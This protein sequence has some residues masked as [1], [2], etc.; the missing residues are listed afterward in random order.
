MN[1]W[2]IAS[3]FISERNKL[4]TD[5]TLHV[6]IRLTRQHRNRWYL[7]Y[8]RVHR[9]GANWAF[10][11]LMHTT[12]GRNACLS[13]RSSRRFVGR[14]TIRFHTH[15]GEFGL[16]RIGF[17]DIHGGILL[18]GVTETRFEIKSF[19]L[20]AVNCSE[21]QRAEFFTWTACNKSRRRP[22]YLEKD[23]ALS[24]SRRPIRPGKTRK[25]LKKIK[26][27]CLK[28]SKE[29]SEIVSIDQVILSTIGPLPPR[30]K[31]PSL[32]ITEDCSPMDPG[33]IYHHHHHQTQSNSRSTQAAVALGTK[34]AAG[35]WVGEQGLL[36]SSGTGRV[37]PEKK[38]IGAREG[39]RTNLGIGRG[40]R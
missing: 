28:S 15:G 39:G 7:V 26:S 40:S 5:I 21:A 27:R 2:C 10:K 12:G 4:P 36:N 20:Q 35:G 8:G 38:K 14:D 32:L 37:N 3:K 11:K 6:L 1:R 34:R 19:L 17:R 13:T 33:S 30:P 25:N 18:R 23:P 16:C 31:S 29:M 24:S 9:I 22:T